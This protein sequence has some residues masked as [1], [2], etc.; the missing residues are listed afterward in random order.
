MGGGDRHLTVQLRQGSKIVRGVAFG[1]GQWCD[2]LNATAGSIE[3]AYR[4]VIN[5]F[6]GF[7]K[8]EI[9]L[10]D[11]RPATTMAAV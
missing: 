10:V 4:A 2:Q 5:E 6:R 1:A 9:H 8:V 3:I 7:R 11:W